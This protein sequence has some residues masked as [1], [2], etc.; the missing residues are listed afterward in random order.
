MAAPAFWISNSIVSYISAP[1]DLKFSMPVEILK[2]YEIIEGIL[3][4]LNFFFV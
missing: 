1:N 3:E 4:I 2:A